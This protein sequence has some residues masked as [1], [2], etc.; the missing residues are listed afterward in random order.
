M[1]L[2]YS[3]SLH[4]SEVA[5]LK[6]EDIPSNINKNSFKNLEYIG[7]FY[8]TYLILTNE[9][10]LYLIDQHA[11]MERIMYEKIKT[12]FAAPHNGAY[13]LLI[14]ITLEYSL[15]EIN[16]I[17]DSSIS[18]ELNKLSILSEAFGENTIIIREIPSWIPAGLEIEFTR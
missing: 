9:N 8:E 12:A 1:I 5:S 3:S 17:L 10:T 2:A 11:A 15:S 18:T 13:E 16:D 7:S 6:V 14:P 4:I